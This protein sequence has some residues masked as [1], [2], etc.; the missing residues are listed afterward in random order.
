[1][2]LP[3]HALNLKGKGHHRKSV[4]FEVRKNWVQIL[5]L[6]FFK[7]RGRQQNEL[8][9]LSSSLQQRSQSHKALPQGRHTEEP[10]QIFVL[11]GNWCPGGL[12][13]KQSTKAK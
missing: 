1:L 6:P 13:T 11:N 9:L 3:V 4:S 12:S 2:L 10:P 8:G 5:A 7:A